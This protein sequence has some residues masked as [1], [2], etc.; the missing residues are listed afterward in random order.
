MIIELDQALRVRAVEICLHFDAR[1]LVETL[2]VVLGPPVCVSH[3]K[4][5]QQNQSAAYLV[6]EEGGARL[7]FQHVGIDV[8]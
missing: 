2:Q 8:V 6:E 5:E 1:E 3:K 4:V 7:V